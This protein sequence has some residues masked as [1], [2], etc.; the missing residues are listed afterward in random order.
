[1]TERINSIMFKKLKSRFKA[2]S[3]GIKR[4]IPHLFRVAVFSAILSGTTVYLIVTYGQHEPCLM[5]SSLFSMYFI[6]L[7][8]FIRIF[9][10]NPQLIFFE[11][12]NDLKT[13][14]ED[15][16]N[17]TDIDDKYKY[18][19][20][21]KFKAV[22]YFVQQLLSRPIFKSNFYDPVE[23]SNFL[24]RTAQTTVNTYNRKWKIM[25]VSEE[26][27]NKFNSIHNP[28]TEGFINNIKKQLVE[29]PS[30]HRRRL[31]FKI[32]LVRL[33]ETSIFEFISIAK[34]E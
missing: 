17:H 5:F 18:Q 11:L 30:P 13:L 7:E 4:S 8:L 6:T 28:R 23:E 1:M 29:E 10:K 16:M 21:E 2:F 32:G 3:N 33:M 19:L 14:S 22:D 31:L 9:V 27:I 12:T 24:D 25:G 15:M 26:L 34:N 20:N